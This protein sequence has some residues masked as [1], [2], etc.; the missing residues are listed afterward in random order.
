MA[1]DYMPITKN[2]RSSLGTAAIAAAN[3]FKDLCD[4]IAG[5]TEIASHQWDTG[6][7][8]VLEAQFSMQNAGQG[9]DLLGLLTQMNDILNTS[10]E[11]TGANRLL[12]IKQFIGRIAGQ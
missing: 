7:Y 2:G 1:N 9:D 4:R 6:D 11:V 12:Q 3:Q 10:T 8:T 5:L